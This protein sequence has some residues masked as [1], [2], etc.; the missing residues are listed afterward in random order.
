VRL[1]HQQRAVG[2]QQE[3]GL[4]LPQQHAVGEEADRAAP[5]DAAV[6]ADLNGRGGG[7]G[8]AGAHVRVHVCLRDC[9]LAYACL[10]TYARSRMR[11]PVRALG[12]HCATRQGA[13][14][15]PSAAGAARGPPGAR[16]R[17]RAWYPTSPP[18][19]QPSSAATR[20]AVLTA[21]TRRGCVTPMAPARSGKAAQP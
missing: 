21:A 11:V 14:R 17:A 4:K 6:V 18:T 10:R 19:R 2:G 7:R 5:A 1:V 9:V 12:F 16:A 3:V 20:S 15:A 13:L 8:C